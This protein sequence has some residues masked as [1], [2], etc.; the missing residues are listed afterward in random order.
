MPVRDTWRYEHDTY[1]RKREYPLRRAVLEGNKALQSADGG[2]K[3]LDGMR[4]YARFPVHEKERLARADPAKYGDLISRDGEARSRATKKLIESNE[5]KKYRV[6]GTGRISIGAPRRVFIGRDE[7][8]NQ[9]FRE[10]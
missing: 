5:G 8:G 7:E 2:V 6:G 1:V 3:E 9:L 4:A 10:W